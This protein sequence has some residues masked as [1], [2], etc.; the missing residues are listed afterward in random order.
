M[1]EHIRYIYFNNE[2]IR[3]HDDPAVE[4]KKKQKHRLNKRVRGN[5][6]NAVNDVLKWIHNRLNEIAV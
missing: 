3:V 5:I 1:P 2:R 4:K 6:N